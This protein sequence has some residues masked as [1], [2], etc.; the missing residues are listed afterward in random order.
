MSLPSL[1]LSKEATIESNESEIENAFIQFISKYQK[2]YSSKTHTSQKYR[3]FKDNYIRIKQHNERNS[4]SYRLG[5]NQ[6]TDM[7]ED[8]FLDVYGSKETELNS[9]SDSRSLSLEN[10]FL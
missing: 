4:V 9:D 1:L 5:I 10:S 3:I 7:T 2:T 8:E 6:F